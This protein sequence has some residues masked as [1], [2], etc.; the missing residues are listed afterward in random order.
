MRV[1]TQMLNETAR[2][3][4]IPVNQ[5]SLLNYINH[6][7]SADNTLLDALNKKNKVS[8]TAVSNY[9]KLEKTAESF[10]EQAEK[11]SASG[12]DS[13]FEKI[14]ADGN[15]EDLYK[16]VESYVN[17]YNSMLSGL[18]KA[19]GVLNEYYGQMLREAAGGFSKPLENIGISIA[20]DGALHVD[21]EKLAS[22]SLD[23]IEK[24]FGASGELTAKTAFIAGRIVDNAQAS[25]Q[26]MS[27]QYDVSGN[28]Y[29]QAASQYNFWG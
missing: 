5:T 19:P 11:L 27:S 8:S 6:D 22:A 4:G 24:I 12:E 15:T 29:S 21:K 1:T 14:K 18:K 7:G 10:R 13:F 20:K 23:D 2:K 26:S 3:T 28:L 25:A 9:Q 17:G 16:T